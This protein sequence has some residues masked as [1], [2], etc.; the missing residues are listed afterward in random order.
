MRLKEEWPSK[1]KKVEIELEID[2][3]DE[4]TNEELEDSIETAIQDYIGTVK[5]IYVSVKNHKQ[6]F[7]DC[8]CISTGTSSDCYKLGCKQHRIMSKGSY[9]PSSNIVSPPDQ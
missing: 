1:K 8:D 7:V 4:R 2:K 6:S 9:V 3:N 5:D